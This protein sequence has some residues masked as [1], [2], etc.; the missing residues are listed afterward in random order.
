M[1][2]HSRTTSRRLALSLLAI[3]SVASCNETMTPSAPT[4]PTPPGPSPQPVATRTITGL[5]WLHSPTGFQPLAGV[6]AWIWLERPRSAGP[7]G[8]VTSDATGRFTFE[9]PEDAL[10]R[11]YTRTPE[12]RQP[13]LSTVRIDQT[14]AT[15]RVVAE[16]H[17]LEARDW[18]VFAVERQLSGRVFE[19]SPT[20]RQPSAD[21]WVQVDG[22]FG[23]GRPLA[24]TRTDANGRFVVCGIED[25][26]WHALVVAKA[27][28]HLAYVKIPQ[29]GSGP[30]DVELRACEVAHRL[31]GGWCH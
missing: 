30:A 4:G 9:V 14:E 19:P 5:M 24:D 7:A 8:A 11:L 22:V 27:G 13:C 1:A 6:R 20:G 31:D 23:D 2:T 12:L 17:L 21:A 15:V 18:P 3:V 26:P 29:D 28:Y 10:V 25:H 16:S